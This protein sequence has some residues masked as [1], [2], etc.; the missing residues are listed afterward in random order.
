MDCRSFRH[1]HLAFVDDTLPGDLLVAAERHRGE[2]ET[3]RAHDTLVRRSLLLARNLPP[4]E[5]SADFM[6]RLQ[7]RLD[8][9]ECGR[10][11]RPG[12]LDAWREREP[13]AEFL[14][15]SAP[16]RWRPGRRSA[17]LAASLAVVAGAAG[18]FDGE[19]AAPPTLAPVVASEAALVGPATMAELERVDPIPASAMMV[20]ASMGVPVWPA[21]ILAGELPVHLVAPAAAVLRR[22]P[23]S[24]PT[25]PTGGVQAVNL[26]LP[27]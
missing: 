21:A 12:A 16:P 20:P 8:A 27:H 7:A 4:V 11:P 26:A 23:V 25:G 6:A 3:C 9:G 24:N 10:P 14:V 5:P 1:H 22:R 2:C 17:A 18:L 13:D 15:A 19:A